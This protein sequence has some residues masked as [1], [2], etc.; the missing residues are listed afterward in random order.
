MKRAAILGA[1]GYTGRELS[2][3]L[4]R[5]PTL[6]LEGAFG[7]R[8]GVEPEPPE[9]ECDAAVEKL[10]WARVSRCDGVFLCTPHA[11]SAALAVRCLELGLKVVD[12]SAD[13]RLKDA[14]QFKAVYQHDHPAPELFPAAV[15]GLVEHARDRVRTARLVANPGCYPTSVLL[16]LKPLLD[17]GL[18]DAQHTIV[19]DCKSGVSGAGK[20]PSSRTVFG[21]SHEN[22]LAYGVG[23]HRHAPEMRLHAGCEHIVFVP[24]LLPVFRG[25]LATIYVKP[26][27]GTGAAEMRACLAE[28]YGGERFV[29]VFGHGLPELNRVQMTNECHLAVADAG[30]LVVLVSAIDNLVKGASGQ[31]LQ[32][33]NLMLG[34]EEGAALS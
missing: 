18:V 11:A 27:V 2:R 29:Q 19:A 17:A 1:S 22:F 3:L 33:M 28:R 26:T 23:V 32:N 6:A 25:I 10:D 34:L 7:A 24:H 20:T 14:A 5:H 30:E 16:A 9:L 12:L 8:E 31:A 21:A 4:R 15:Y 13:F